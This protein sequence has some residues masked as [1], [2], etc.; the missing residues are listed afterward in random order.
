M[1]ILA[2]LTTVFAVTIALGA[3]GV[4]LA[5][6]DPTV[7]AARSTGAVG[8][9]ADG[10]LGFPTPPSAALKAAVDAVNIKRRAVYT[11]LAA[12]RNVTIQEVAGATACELLG[13][14]VGPGQMYRT[15]AGAWKTNNGS[16]EKPPFC[17]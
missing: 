12:K 4:A 11:D 7:D 15:A 14:R 5:Q 1:T 16:V 2:R 6:S 8:E 17:P 10:Y 9:Q 3:A 13:S